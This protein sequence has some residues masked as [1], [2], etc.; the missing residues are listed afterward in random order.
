MESTTDA[1]HEIPESNWIVY[2][3]EVDNATNENSGE[4]EPEDQQ[5]D[6]AHTKLKGGE[7]KNKGRGSPGR[8]KKAKLKKRLSVSSA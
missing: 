1:I 8:Y 4:Q 5:E 6:E 3:D 7:G 2:T